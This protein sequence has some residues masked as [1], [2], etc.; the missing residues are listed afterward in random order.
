MMGGGPLM[1]IETLGVIMQAFILGQ[2]SGSI[3][4]LE[5][6]GIGPLIGSRY[7]DAVKEIVRLA[8]VVRVRDAASLNWIYENEKRVDAQLIQDPA[9]NYVRTRKKYINSRRKW[10]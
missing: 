2:K 9:I 6:C 10:Q 3:T 7:S 8:S 1:H 5:G 4:V